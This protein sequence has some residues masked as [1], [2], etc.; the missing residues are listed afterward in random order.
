[1]V[2]EF[3][4]PHPTPPLWLAT[5]RNHPVRT[6]TT[7]YRVHSC[8]LPTLANVA[9]LFCLPSSPSRESA[10]IWQFCLLLSPF[11]I[12][13]AFSVFQAGY[14]GVKNAALSIVTHCQRAPLPHSQAFPSPQP[15][16]FSVP[17]PAPRNPLT[18]G[19]YPCHPTRPSQSSLLANGGPLLAILYIQKSLRF[20]AISNFLH[21][22]P[23]QAAFT[24]KLAG[25]PF[26]RCRGRVVQIQSVSPVFPH[27]SSLIEFR[28][29][30][31][32][33]FA[34][35]FACSYFEAV[36]EG[37][38][39][40][41]WVRNVL[42]FLQYSLLSSPTTETHRISPGTCYGILVGGLGKRPPSRPLQGHHCHCHQV[43][44]Q[45]PQGLRHEPCNRS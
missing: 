14:F 23:A 33:C 13:H 40:G 1:M 11:A 41:L 22:P 4:E 37:S 15:I 16:P 18:A 39:V 2:C 32:A 19:H 43:L 10:Y 6:K 27:T 17:S 30:T 26:S 31:A 25:S 12:S 29:V 7:Q 36:L 20:V 44:G 21:G 9:K 3:C 38:K 34:S 24:Y 5:Q 45:Y 35:R 28:A 8:P 42:W